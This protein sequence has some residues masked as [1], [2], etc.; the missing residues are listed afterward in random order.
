[1]SDYNIVDTN[2]GIG[3]LYKDKTGDHIVIDMAVDCFGD[4]GNISLLKLHASGGIV[5][6]RQPQEVLDMEYMGRVNMQPF[7]DEVDRTQ[8]MYYSK[9]RNHEE[10]VELYKKYKAYLDREEQEVKRVLENQTTEK[11]F[12]RQRWLEL[13]E[14]MREYLG[15]EA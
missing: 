10:V 11:E 1:M 12:F 6:V 3:N 9:K 13:D 15:M 4:I 8:F 2:I 5:K 7:Y 14:M